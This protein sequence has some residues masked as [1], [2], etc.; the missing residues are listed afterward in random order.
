MRTAT[1]LLIIALMCTSCHI[2]KNS[3]DKGQA[4]YEILEYPIENG[5]GEDYYP[6]ELKAYDDER[7]ILSARHV[8]WGRTAF[9]ETSNAGKDW[10]KKSSDNEKGFYENLCVGKDGRLYCSSPHGFGEDTK[11]HD[12]ILSSDNAGESWITLCEFNEEIEGLTVNDGGVFVQIF[13]KTGPKSTRSI[14][15]SDDGCN[16]WRTLVKDNHLASHFGDNIVADLAR[17]NRHLIVSVNT[18]TQ[19][20]DTIRNNCQT[21]NQVIAGEDIIGIWNGRRADYY[22]IV[23]DTAVYMSRIRY[24]LPR[25][26]HVPTQIHQHGDIVYTSVLVPSDMS[27]IEMFIS[28]DRAK[29][30]TQVNTN[31]SFSHE[32]DNVWTPAGSAWFMAGYKDRIVSYCVV[33]KDGQRQDFIRIIRPKVD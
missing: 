3:D 11:T 26:S 7:W 32:Y 5:I 23:K 18:K 27:R 13:K 2:R 33:E 4:R 21:T 14:M 30:W 8:S 10:E 20:L 1:S 16:S 12:R 6:S 19:D 15:V 17:E 29:S 22:R 31:N 25:T 28:T 24:D 9:F